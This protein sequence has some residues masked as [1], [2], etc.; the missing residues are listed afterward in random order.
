MSLCALFAPSPLIAISQLAGVRA[1]HGVGK[2]EVH[3]LVHW[4]YASDALLQEIGAV[5]SRMV[6]GSPEVKRITLVPQSW[7]DDAISVGIPGMYAEIKAR[8]GGVNY[9]EIYYPHDV[10]G[11]LYQL[12]S[13]ANPQARRICTGDNMGHV[14]D[15]EVFYSYL[16]AP[17]QYSS[18]LLRR[19]YVSIKDA[20]APP[21]A[22]APPQT[23][24][25]FRPHMVSAP[26]PVDQA[27]NFLSDLPLVVP[28]RQTVRSVLDDCIAACPDLADYL[29]DLL[30]RFS[31]RRIYTL[32]AQN[33][34]ECGTMDFEQDVAMWCEV[35]R[36]HCTAG[37][38]ILLKTHPAETLPRSE[39][40]AEHLGGDYTV[41]ALDRRFVRYP[42]E[43][44]GPLVRGTSVIS[45]SMPV[46]SL[47]YL[48]DA[49]CIQPF[50]NQFIECWFPRNVWRFYQ[51]GLSLFTEPL[52][53][54]DKWNGKGALWRAPLA[55]RKS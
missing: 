23:V 22:Y 5:I 25:S 12:L 38:V 49:T 36:R 41:V 50:S 28:D 15:R 1:Q 32:C 46:L 34:A 48:Y 53:N 9:D 43:L 47:R 40:V 51:N 8:L 16:A 35:I 19:L 31:G 44:C 42:I 10:M 26:I 3:M 7:V 33:F 52:A 18:G 11:N 21:K 4:A 13:G 39:K 29:K 45:T 2:A 55:L 20:F 37:S 14:F 6:S 27:G 54:F 30:D 17:P 24:P